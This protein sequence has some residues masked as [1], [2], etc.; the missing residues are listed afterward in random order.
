M[1]RQ[2]LVHPLDRRFLQVLQRTNVF[3]PLQRYQLTTVTYCVL[4][5]VSCNTHGFYMVDALY[6]NDDL[7]SAIEASKQLAELLK[8]AGFH[9]RK[10]STDDPRV[11]KH[12]SDVL[13]EFSP[14]TELDSAANV[15]HWDIGIQDSNIITDRKTH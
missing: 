5:T 1:C 2:I 15:K 12:V 6:G 13:K 9:L 7:E 11:L 14:E 8:V 10:Q 3:Q 4:R